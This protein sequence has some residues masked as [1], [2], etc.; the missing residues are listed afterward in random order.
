[1]FVGVGVRIPGAFFFDPHSAGVPTITRARTSIEQPSQRFIP[2]FLERHPLEPGNSP[3]P[4]GPE[5]PVQ[6]R[7]ILGKPPALLDVTI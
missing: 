5:T 7:S 2:R 1:M 3:G 4:Q 6:N